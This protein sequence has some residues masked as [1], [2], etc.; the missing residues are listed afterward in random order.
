MGSSEGSGIELGAPA[1]QSPEEIVRGAVDTLIFDIEA[2]ISMLLETRERLRAITRFADR[3]SSDAL[4]E[5]ITT[6]VQAVKARGEE[7]AAVV[8]ERQTLVQEALV[9]ARALKGLEAGSGVP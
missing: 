7:I 9:N 3:L 6:E 8:N 1:Q 4:E 5:L 2:K